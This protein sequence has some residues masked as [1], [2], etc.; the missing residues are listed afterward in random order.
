[1][2]SSEQATTFM[3]AIALLG[4]RSVDHIREAALATLAPPPDRRDEFD[5]LFRMWLHGEEQVLHAGEGEDEETG[6]KENGSSLEQLAPEQGEA[7][8]EHASIE[9][10]LTRREF[11]VRADSLPAFQRQIGHALP[12]RRSF[13]TEISKTPGALDLRRSLRS[14]VRNGGDIPSPVWRKRRQAPRRLLLLIDVSGSMKQYTPGFLEMAHAAVQGAARVE[15]FTFGTRLTRL[16][17]ALRVRDRSMAVARASSLVDDWGGGTRIG[18]SLLAFLSTPRFAALANGSCVVILSDGLER[19]DHAPMELAISRLRGR[20]WR[21]TFVT[22]LAGDP[23]FRPETAAMK[24]ILP[25][26]DDLIDG[27]SVACVADFLLSLA[28]SAPAAISIWRRA[29]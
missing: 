14:I 23:R 25:M 19:G 10:R 20:A 22:P 7:G 17:S 6:V 15:V 18:P 29:S 21:L 4:P 5:A 2:A 8:G 26:L 11:S 24:A 27:S 12:K 1:M 9:E 13:R 16:T 28:R 3:Q